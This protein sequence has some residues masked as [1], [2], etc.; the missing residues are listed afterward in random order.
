MAG[1]PM[2]DKTRALVDLQKSIA[3]LEAEFPTLPDTISGL[4]K[5]M[6]SERTRLVSEIE[7]G[8]RSMTGEAEGVARFKAM[9]GTKRFY[10]PL[11]DILIRREIAE[12]ASYNI[13]D[14]NLYRY[15]A[16]STSDDEFVKL[17]KDS[18]M[19]DVQMEVFQDKMLKKCMSVTR[20]YPIDSAV[21]R[22]K[23]MVLFLFCSL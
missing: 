15:C 16:M 11:L 2:L 17:P 3:L 12:A 18:S 10:M 7:S 19:F 1:T 20:R 13:L 14:D 6:A 21:E 4:H 22:E 5:S 9:F 8:F 23:I